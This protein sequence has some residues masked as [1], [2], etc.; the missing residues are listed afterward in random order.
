MSEKRL[1]LRK[2]EGVPLRNKM[3]QETASAFNIQLCQQNAPAFI[4]VM[5]VKKNAQGVITPVTNQ[6]TKAVMALAYR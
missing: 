6:N 1:I 5:N 4:R 2:D 3:N